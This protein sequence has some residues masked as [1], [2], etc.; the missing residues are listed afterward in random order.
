[1]SKH[2]SVFDQDFQIVEEDS[3][4]NYQ[5]GLTSKLDSIPS[6]FDQNAINEISAQINEAG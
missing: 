4:Y 6:A 2:R 3:K 5:S 1:M